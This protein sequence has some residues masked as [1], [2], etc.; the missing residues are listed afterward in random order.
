MRGICQSLVVLRDYY[1]SDSVAAML[2]DNANLASLIQQPAG[3]EKHSKSSGAGRDI[4]DILELVESVFANNLATEETE[5]ADAQSEYEKISQE[6]KVTTTSVQQD[7]NYS[8]DRETASQEHK[9]V[10]DC[11]GKKDA[12]QLSLETVV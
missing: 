11:F 6:N 8:L 5:E 10:L 9:A 2:Q 3:P 12:L 1:A 7:V 4:I